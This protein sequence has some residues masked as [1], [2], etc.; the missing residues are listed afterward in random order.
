MALSGWAAASFK[1][2]ARDSW[3]GWT[4]EQQWRP[5]HL[6]VNNQR[7]L[8]LPGIELPNLAAGIRLPEPRSTAH[9]SPTR[10]TNANT[11]SERSF[12][13]LVADRQAAILSRLIQ[14]EER[15]KTAMT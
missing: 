5:L 6:V 10:F 3:I 2:G 11:R 7:F 12:I 13:D 8:M 15:T 1:V 4:P 14:A 9:R